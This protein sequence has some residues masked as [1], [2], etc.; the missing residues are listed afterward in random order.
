MR[1]YTYTLRIDTTVE[2]GGLQVDEIERLQGALQDA[3]DVVNDALPDG[4]YCKV[5]ET[6]AGVDLSAVR[7][8]EE[9]GR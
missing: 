5:D 2:G 9:M 1:L 4:Y 8:L 6:G 3:E 7:R